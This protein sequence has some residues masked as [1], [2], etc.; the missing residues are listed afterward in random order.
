MISGGSAYKVAITGDRRRT[1]ILVPV[2]VVSP[3]LVYGTVTGPAEAAPSD[4]EEIIDQEMEARQRGSLEEN[5][6]V[7]DG[8]RDIWADDYQG[9]ERGFISEA[10]SGSDGTFPTPLVLSLSFSGVNLLQAV[11]VAFPDDPGAGVAADFTVAV[12]ANG[13][14]ISTE[15][16]TG[17]ESAIYEITGLVA[18]G[19]DGI[20]VTITKWS[21]PGRRARVLELLPGIARDFSGDDV[22]SA[23]IRM[24]AS[25]T[26]T[27]QPYGTASL[28]IDNTDR[29]FDPR[30]KNSLFL[31]LEERQQV[32]V[33]LGVD[34]ESG[35]TA[36]IPVG[37]YYLQNGGWSSAN[38]WMAMSWKLVDII[39][40]L[41][42]RTFTAPDPLPTTLEGWVAALVGQ[43]G[44]GFAGRYYVAPPYSTSTVTVSQASDV[45]G[46][47]CETI[48]RWLC[49]AT[50][51]YARA[52]AETGD[53][54]VRGPG[55]SGGE[56]LL[57]NMGDYPTLSTNDKMGRITFRLPEE[58]Y[59]VDGDDTTANS[60]T[61]SNPF[62]RTEEKAESAGQY[63]LESYGGNKITTK[64]RGDPANE[65]GDVV[66][67]ELL[68]GDA[69][70]GR[71]LS[72][73]FSFSTGI[74]RDC[75]TTLLQ[76]EGE[77]LYANRV[78]LD[79]DTAWTVPA[80]ITTIHVVLVGGGSAGGHG[81]PGTIEPA[82]ED[83]KEGWVTGQTGEAGQDGPGG[84][85]WT[86]TLSVT[87]GDTIQAL[88]GR[89]GR[90][91]SA[92]SPSPGGNTTFGAYSSANGQVYDPSYT[93][94]TSG[95]A[96]GRSGIQSPRVNRGEGGKGGSG[97]SPGRGRW[98]KIYDIHGNWTGRYRLL[99]YEE[100]GEGSYGKHGASGC[101]IIYYDKEGTA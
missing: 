67:V 1:R 58:D 71:I 33:Y 10:L 73:T 93:D 62:I 64:G 49:Q 8:S 99:E 39:G 14:V 91:Y 54:F 59:T 13:T 70:V 41:S 7:L 81:L 80:G 61:V 72:Q 11:T 3:D 86:G 27:T 16:V 40:L 19:A 76:P 15:A 34:L 79:Q 29:L 65:I 90:E 68:D 88:I 32:P 24:Q 9:G 84:L 95:R 97:G 2:R 92:Q 47:T 60:L 18:Y 4:L 101:V 77:L 96:Y 26:G 30:E 94:V 57:D 55:R 45:D 75:V 31:S 28:T 63:I 44:A 22:I 23:S 83:M 5:F 66:T 82:E 12:S 74:L 17:N 85:I 87:P 52:S 6:W 37:V 38:S 46:K 78:E 51:T 35:D 53:L 69:T 48:L 42:R 89:G 25:F 100:G 50:G 20:T 98:R 36:W 21:L 56:I 43:L